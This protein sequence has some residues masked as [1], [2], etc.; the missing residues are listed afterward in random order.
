[1]TA[2]MNDKCEAREVRGH[3][4]NVQVWRVYVVS[5]RLPLGLT[6]LKTAYFPRP[7]LMP[8]RE[9]DELQFFDDI[10]VGNVEVVF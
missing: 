9:H 6:S 5:W 4:R 8:P 1:M 10:G 3:T 7:G 2:E